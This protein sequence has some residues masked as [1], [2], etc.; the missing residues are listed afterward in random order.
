MI[1]EAIR[2]LEEAGRHPD[3]EPAT[4]MVPGRLI[5]RATVQTS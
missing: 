1:N 5:S 4:I 3:R 2:M